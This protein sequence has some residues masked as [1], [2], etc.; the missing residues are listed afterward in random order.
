MVVELE[1]ECR[2]FREGEALLLQ[3]ED[4]WPDPM[5]FQHRAGSRH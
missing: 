4:M 2:D 3:R 1:L 5:H